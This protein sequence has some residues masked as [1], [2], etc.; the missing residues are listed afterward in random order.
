MKRHGFMWSEGPEY[1]DLELF[2][3]SEYIREISFKRELLRMALIYAGFQVK[4]RSAGKIHNVCLSY[5][6]YPSKV[7]S[8]H[9]TG[10]HPEHATFT[11]R[12]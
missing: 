4:N 5:Q 8:T 6:P 12:L 11:K 7:V 9:R 10:T 3:G 1:P 2:L